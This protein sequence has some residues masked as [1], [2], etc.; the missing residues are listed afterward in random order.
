MQLYTAIINTFW[1]IGVLVVFV[2]NR[3]LTRQPAIEMLFKTG[4]TFF[5]VN[6][7]NSFP[8]RVNYISY[9]NRSMKYF[10]RIQKIDHIFNR[11]FLFYKT[12]LSRS[13]IVGWNHTIIYIWN[14]LWKITLSLMILFHFSAKSRGHIRPGRFEKKIML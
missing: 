11:Y 1:Q 8:G 4:K 6:F 14:L 10:L 9:I 5:F 13:F 12:T 2:V 7:S 3:V